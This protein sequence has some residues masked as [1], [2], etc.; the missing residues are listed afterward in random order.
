MIDPQQNGLNFPIAFGAED[1][2]IQ[3]FPA[4]TNWASAPNNVNEAI[5]RIAAALVVSTGGKPIP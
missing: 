5:E 3:H 1:K 2:F 4:S